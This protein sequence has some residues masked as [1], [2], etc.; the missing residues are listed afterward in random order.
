MDAA[1]TLQTT[2]LV[3]VPLAALLIWARVSELE[4][5]RRARRRNGDGGRRSDGARKD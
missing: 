4:R 5:E 3:L 2:A 1:E